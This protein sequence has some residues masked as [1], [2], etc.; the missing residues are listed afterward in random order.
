MRFDA[1]IGGPKLNVIIRL[2]FH[3]RIGA[4]KLNVIIRLCFDA[5]IAAPKLNYQTKMDRPRKEVVKRT[6]E[7][8]FETLEEQHMSS[9]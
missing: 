5:P 1:P 7:F 6:I 4:P 9:E 2:G 3:A 8:T